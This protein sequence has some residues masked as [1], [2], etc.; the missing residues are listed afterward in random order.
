MSKKVARQQKNNRDEQK[1]V[2][3]AYGLPPAIQCL[4]ST[5]PVRMVI[6]LYP[7][8]GR[9]INQINIQDHL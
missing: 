4:H 7:I 5:C 9:L 3:L 8:N 6:L 1:K 2:D